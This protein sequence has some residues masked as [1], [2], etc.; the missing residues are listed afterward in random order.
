VDWASD[1]HDALVQD[2]TGRTLAELTVG[3]DE[4]G[5]AQLGETLAGLGVERVAL[6]RPDG[7]LVEA[8]LDRGFEVLAIHPNQVKA[9]RPRFSVAGGKSDRFDAFVLCELARTDSHRFRALR[10]DSDETKALKALTR[11]REDLVATRV[12]LANQLRA[13]LERF[14]PGAARIFAEV[15]SPIALAF[16]ERYPSPVDARGLGEKR[17][18]GF[19]CRHGY[20]GRRAPAELLE[21]LRGG[22]HGGAA[23]LEVEARRAVVLALVAALRPLVGQIKQLSAQIAGAVRAHPD[24]EIFLSLFRDPNSTVTAARL[25]A[26]LG[27]CRVRYPSAEAMSADAGMSPVAIESGKRKVAAFRRGCD[28]R[29]RA[30]VACLADSTRHHNPWARAVYRRARARGCEHPHAIRI[31]GRAWLRVVWRMW[32]DRRPYDP[33]HHRALTRQL[34]AGG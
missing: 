9:S 32:Q 25:V 29:L 15:D 11:A 24:G 2:E 14:W 26:E 17:L 4:R 19:L 23:E 27:D 7:L 8:L 31:L 5:L 20:C 6:E 33:T 22:P 12:S 21:R 10:P 30:A 3:H 1:K 28:H 16:C 34:A 13:E 18:R